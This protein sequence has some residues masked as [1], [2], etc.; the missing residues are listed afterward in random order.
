M[1]DVDYWQE[2]WST[3][4][5]NKLRSFLTGFGVFW[6]IFML[7]VLIGV[8]NSFKGGMS[9]IVDGFSPNSCFFWS[10]LTSEPYQ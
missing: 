5:R 4:S 2:I 8:S 3:I 1:F 7:V 9:K 6:G 10:D